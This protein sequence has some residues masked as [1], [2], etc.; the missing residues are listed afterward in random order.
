MKMF[1][2]QTVQHNTTS[3]PGAKCTQYQYQ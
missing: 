1:G 2:Q 3:L